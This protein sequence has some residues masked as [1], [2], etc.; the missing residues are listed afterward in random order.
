MAPVRRVAGSLPLAAVLLVGGALWVWDPGHGEESRLAP[1]TDPPPQPARLPPA[2]PLGPA[3]ALL[4]AGEADGADRALRELAGTWDS[5][6]ADLT[7]LRGLYAYR[8]GRLALADDLLAAVEGGAL[9]D[10]RIFVLADIAARAG[11]PERSLE[12]L[13]RL[14]EHHPDSPLRTDAFVRAVQ[15][16]LAAGRPHGAQLVAESARGEELA[17]EA[18]VELETLAWEAAL[19]AGDLPR[20]V[21]TARRLLTH[22]PVTAERL[23]VRHRFDLSPLVEPTWLLTPEELL[24]RARN[25]LAAQRP[26]AAWEAVVAVPLEARDLSWRL[27]AAEVLIADRRGGE[28]LAV[29]AGL[30]EPAAAEAARIEWLRARAA[31]ALSSASASRH[32]LP[33]R[34]RVAMR[35][36]AEESLWRVVQLGG[37]RALALEALREIHLQLREEE[38]TEEAIQVLYLIRQLE[39]SDRTGARFLWEKGWQEY[40][41]RNHAGAVGFWSELHALYP[42]S[43]FS[44]PA[45]YWTARASAALGRDDRARELLRRVAEADTTDFYRRHALRR[46]AGAGPDPEPDDPPPAEPWPEDP[47]LARARFLTDAG[48][49]ALA[50]VEL[51]AVAQGAEPRAQ[52]ALRGL[53]DARL[54]NR[55]RSLAALR[56][57]FP[58]LGGPH[59][60]GLP[61]AALRLYYPL[62][63]EAAVAQYAARHGLSADLVLAVVH[64]ESG[65]DPRATS[66]AG[67]R[68]L[69]QVMPATGR[70]VA[71][72]LGV[73]YSSSRLYDPHFSLALGTRYLR[74]V[75]DMFDG[76]M[77]LALAG[78]NG[79]PYRIQRLWNRTGR[80]A[81]IDLFVESLEITESRLYVK[82]VLTLEDSYR[83]LRTRE[84][85]LGPRLE[86]S[87][88]ILA[89]G[90]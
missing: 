53:I 32:P 54:G 18:A 13:A 56:A 25:L 65:F 81:E 23:G 47:R 90:P 89:S 1:T 37:D 82:R 34:D 39:P 58:A 35:G 48:L 51:A 87:D 52:Q 3:A 43:G 20:Q 49:D 7:L 16:E 71:R 6:D 60:A 55:P 21:E 8:D 27:V 69:M 41:R 38:R 61:A 14:L 50:A 24:A 45:L 2:E 36:R 40:R 12:L 29:L 77:E 19:R 75:L 46:L 28:A 17:G 15:L 30:D 11:A 31:L 42:D 10:W 85:R 66:R 68:G 44:R 62:D 64:Q 76:D 9:E 57:A 83:Q 67:A 22:F 86:A 78:Y 59:Q 63:F 4:R 73:P 88:A 79:G 80:R 84:G 5:S 72:R 70:E 26:A 33:A 74:Q